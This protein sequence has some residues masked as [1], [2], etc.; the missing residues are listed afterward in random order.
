M[1][2]GTVLVLTT[3]NLWLTIRISL[4]LCSRFGPRAT[5]SARLGFYLARQDKVAFGIPFRYENVQRP[6][7]STCPMQK[8]DMQITRLHL[9]VRGVNHFCLSCCLSQKRYSAII[10]V[11]LLG[12][13]REEGLPL[14]APSA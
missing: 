14:L 13:E 7:V 6:P 5:R 11:I 1:T 10:V 8:N 2:F 4:N 9:K 12:V 3:L